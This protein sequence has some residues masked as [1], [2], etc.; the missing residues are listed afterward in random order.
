ML[1]LFYQGDFRVLE[2]PYYLCLKNPAKSLRTGMV[3]PI[4]LE[5]LFFVRKSSSIYTP[6]PFNALSLTKDDKPRIPDRVFYNCLLTAAPANTKYVKSAPGER[7]RSEPFDPNQQIP[8]TWWILFRLFHQQIPKFEFGL[9]LNIGSGVGVCDL[10]MLFEWIMFCFY[11]FLI[12]MKDKFLAAFLAGFSYVGIS[13]RKI[14]KN[15]A[16]NYIV[17]SLINWAGGAD[18]RFEILCQKVRDLGNSPYP[19]V[20][21][22]FVRPPS[23]KTCKLI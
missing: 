12:F 10:F 13:D 2:T 20:L 4:T 17:S 3:A 14:L 18:N 16:T 23:P 19:V 7:K 1:Y 22:V 11:L 8:L 15:Y 5:F 9:I 21:P 6:Y